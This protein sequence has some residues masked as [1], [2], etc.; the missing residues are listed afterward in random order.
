MNVICKQA[1]HNRE[2]KIAFY[3]IFLQ[4]RKTGAYPE[5]FDPLKATSI[6]IDV[7]TE[8]GPQNV[9][10]GKL[11]F[12]NVPAIFLEASMFELLSPQYVGIEL[13]EN[14]RLSNN[15][16]EAI[17]DL[18]K[19]GFK[20]C[21]DD[22]GFEKIDYLPLLNKCHYVKINIKDNPYD[23]EELKEVISIL[24]SLKKGIIAKNIESKDDYERAY[25]LGFEYFQ[26]MYLSKPA[27]V[28]DTRTISFLKSTIL[29]IYNAIKSKNIK[30]VVDV[31]EKDIGVTYKLLKFVNSAYFPKAREFSNVEDA[32]VYLGLENIAKFTI[33]LAL[34]DMFTD[35]DE[36]ELWKR[37]LFRASVSEKIS[38][39]YAMDMKDKAY[40]MGLFSLSWEILG[41][42]PAELARTLALDKE[43]IEAYENRIS[44][45]GFILSL[46]DLLEDRMEEE[47]IKKVAKII[48]ASPERV[49]EIIN[50]ARQESEKFVG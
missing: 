20:F 19:E 38:E 17:D 42:K 33:V 22:F 44:T 9:G 29:Q 5:G 48:G 41:Q 8:T 4:D 27:M 28:R 50:E 15:L 43:I 36:K 14:K 16:L 46:V 32:V 39:V 7:L 6:S 18:I 25:E 13:V 34:S 26:G 11:V 2:G 30:K 31:I 1:I 10:N 47:T 24:K 35:E 49:K 37:A 45:L 3:E 23:Q 40:L 21:I 12:V